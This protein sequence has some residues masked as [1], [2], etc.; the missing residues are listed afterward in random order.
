M[1]QSEYVP[2]I[3]DGDTQIVCLPETFRFKGNKVKLTK[4]GSKVFIEPEKFDV[5]AW[6]KDLRE[7]ADPDFMREGRPPQGE[8]GV[9]DPLD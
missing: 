7:N 1:S 5:K 8:A 9:R 2:L 4:Q 3:N 6:L